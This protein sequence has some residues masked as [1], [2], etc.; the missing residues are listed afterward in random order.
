MAWV[1]LV[2]GFLGAVVPST[3][4][5]FDQY[6]WSVIS[7][8]I[9]SQE[10]WTISPLRTQLSFTSHRRQALGFLWLLQPV[11]WASGSLSLCCEVSLSTPVSFNSI[12][13][14]CRNWV[15]FWVPI[16]PPSVWPCVLT[17]TP[18][19]PHGNWKKMPLPFMLSLYLSFPFLQAKSQ[20]GV[21]W[22]RSYC[23]PLC[24]LSL[25]CPL[26]NFSKT[27][28]RAGISLISPKL[29]PVSSSSS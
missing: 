27:G 4:A 14:P 1:T 21:V 24:L 12:F 19:I 15:S 11:P 26:S 25:F 6:L 23:L 28:K 20:E 18:G 16:R 29:W 9:C 8:C 10:G 17:S 7:A 2:L 3:V 13:I 22:N 5:V